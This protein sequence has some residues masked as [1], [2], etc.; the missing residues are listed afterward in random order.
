MRM[1]AKERARG[2]MEREGG[3]ERK[4]RSKERESEPQIEGGVWGLSGQIS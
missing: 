2:E 3:R 1:G 4:Y